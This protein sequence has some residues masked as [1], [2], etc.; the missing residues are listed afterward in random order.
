MAIISRPSSGGTEEVE[1]LP[2]TLDFKVYR[3]DSLDVMLRLKDAARK[4]ID[5]SGFVPLMQL[6]DTLNS[7]AATPEITLNYLDTGTLRIYLADTSLLL[8]NTVY[9]YD[10][11]LTDSTGQKR[12]ILAGT[13][14][15]TADVSQ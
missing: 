13:V 2:Q 8:V 14:T 1:L 11:Q 12:T 5:L 4:P 6:K 7:V 9:S 15:V 3:G 10:L